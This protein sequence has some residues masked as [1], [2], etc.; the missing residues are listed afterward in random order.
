MTDML[1]LARAAKKAAIHLAATPH[2]ARGAA[3]LAFA[4]TLRARQE[5]IFAANAADVEQARAEEFDGPLLKRLRF[6]AA[7]LGEVLEGI[8]ALA[9]LP[10]P[11][12]MTQRATELSPGLNL[13]RVACPIGVIGVIFESRPDA[14]AQIASLCLKSGNAVLLKGGREAARTNRAL[15]AALVEATNAAGIPQGW[16]GLLESREEVAQMLRLDAYIDLII[17][18][19]SNG[20]VRHIMENSRIPVLGHA[21]GLCAVYID[22]AAD[23]DMAV[24]VAVDSKA[25]YVAVC[26]AAETL[27]VHREIAPKALPPLAQAMAKAGVRLKGCARTR[28]LIPCEAAEDTDYDTEYLD[29]VMAV[30]VVDSL[31]EAVAHINA[32]GSGHTDCIVTADA[33]AA[34]AFLALVDSAGVYHNCSTRFADGFRYGLGAEVGVATGKLHARGPMGL[35]GL[36]TYKYQL[37]GEGHTVAEFADGKRRFTHRA[38]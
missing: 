7:K 2:E 10:D 3:L 23:I 27:L 25:Q 9:E 6:D 1:E 21:D 8:A 38:L 37:L 15:F 5:E 4:E 18:R 20:F 34:R 35:E 12:G 11:I 19:G 31:E 14:L 28:A 16:A 29:Y 33:G 32:H 30:R 26:N 22:R 17:P 13:Y 24:R 36:C